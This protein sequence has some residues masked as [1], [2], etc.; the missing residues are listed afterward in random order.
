MSEWIYY[1]AKQKKPKV[2]QT[3]KTEQI[4]QTKKIKQ[5]EHSIKSFFPLTKEQQINLSNASSSEKTQ[6]LEL[7]NK[8]FIYLNEN[9]NNIL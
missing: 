1:V 4:E 8:M 2:E 5:I 6:V 3:E 7:Y 9:I